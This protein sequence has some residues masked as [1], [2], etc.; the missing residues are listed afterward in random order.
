MHKPVIVFVA[1]ALCAG[2]VQAA[3]QDR[4]ARDRSVI[5]DRVVLIDRYQGR[6]RD[7]REQQTERVTRTLKIGASG[8]LHIANIA[9]NVTVTRGG[10]NEATVEV[11]KTARGRTPEDAKE[12]LGLVQVDISERS[13]RAEIKTRYPQWDEFRRNNRRNINVSVALTVTAPAGTRLTVNSISGDISAQDI[14]G[15]L[16]LESV[17]GAVRIGNGGRVAGAKSISGNVEVVDTEIDGQLEASSVSGTVLLRNLKARGLNVDSVSGSVSLQD[18]VC[19]RVDAQSVSGDVDFSGPLAKGGRYELT[20]HSGH[21]RV[22]VAGGTGFELEATSFSGSVRSDIPLN[23]QANDSS[24]RRQRTLRGVYGD[25][26][27]VLDLTTFS[28]SIVITKR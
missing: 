15:D 16:S 5:R 25:G 21:V 17:S 19:D 28:G 3:A 18:V 7:Q 26:S 22:A 4:P 11:V 12:L 9:G 2:A 27:A 8:E 24:R 23:A 20:S 10:G 14:K 1:A 13:G 6:D